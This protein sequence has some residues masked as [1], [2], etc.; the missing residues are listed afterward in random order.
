MVIIDNRKENVSMKRKNE[1]EKSFFANGRYW[2]KESA[3]KFRDYQSEF[4]KKRYRTFVVRFS[5]NSE[6]DLIKYLEDKSS[7]TDY[8]RNLVIDD[9]MAHGLL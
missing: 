2:T 4:I 3:Q 6:P 1:S 8:I 9:M 7:K 5:K